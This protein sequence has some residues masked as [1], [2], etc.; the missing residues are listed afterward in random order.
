MLGII[1][2]GATTL[3]CLGAAMR[4]QAV[5]RFETEEKMFCTYLWRTLI[6]FFSL[7]RLC[8]R[9]V[10][11]PLTLKSVWHNEIKQRSPAASCRWSASGEE[12]KEERKKN[13]TPKHHTRAFCDTCHIL[14]KAP[15]PLLG[16]ASSSLKIREGAR[17]SLGARWQPRED[18]ERGGLSRVCWK[19]TINGEKDSAGVNS[20]PPAFTSLQAKWKDP[21]RPER[22]ASPP[23][24]WQKG[25]ERQTHL[26]QRVAAASC[27]PLWRFSL[28][29]K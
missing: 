3:R 22:N 9:L 13:P 6:L 17:V 27:P 20:C 1:F 14:R 8:S 26:E 2:T 24:S 10:P 16:R 18:G 23:S 11:H 4:G 28:Q 12:K 15:Q 19:D 29:P 25:S 5:R 7:P 21:E